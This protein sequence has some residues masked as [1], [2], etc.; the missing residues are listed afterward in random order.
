MCV[1]EGVLA[2]FFSGIVPKHITCFV[3]ATDLINFIL[4]GQVAP[5]E[6][7]YSNS[8]CL[9]PFITLSGNGTV[10]SMSYSSFAAIAISDSDWRLFI[11]D[12]THRLRD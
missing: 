5:I 9:Q 11:A 1:K 6:A 10:T 12:N 4:C 7:L 8:A 2:N 3:G